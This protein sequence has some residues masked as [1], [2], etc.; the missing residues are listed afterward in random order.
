[1]IQKHVDH[2][3]DD[4]KEEV[5]ELKAQ[6]NRYATQNEQ[7]DKRVNELFPQVLRAQSDISSITG[8]VKLKC[9]LEE[10]TKFGKNLQ[11]YP[12]RSDFKLLEDKMDSLATLSDYHD[13][14]LKIE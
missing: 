9:N 1:M 5:R 7:R 3:L 2:G 10:L 14:D 6:L 4:L 8:E 13:L 12:L 11:D